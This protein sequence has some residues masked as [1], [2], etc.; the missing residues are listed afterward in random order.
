M[1]TLRLAYY[2][3]GRSEELELDDRV[4][5]ASCVADV[6]FAAVGFGVWAAVLVDGSAEVLRFLMYV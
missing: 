6:V 2:N 1:I 4:S 5:S 3:G